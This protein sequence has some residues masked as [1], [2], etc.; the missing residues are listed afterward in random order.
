MNQPNLDLYLVWRYNICHFPIDVLYLWIGQNLKNQPNLVLYLVRRSKIFV[1][2][3]TLV[4]YM[5][6]YRFYSTDSVTSLKQHIEYFNFRC[7]IQLDLPILGRTHFLSLFRSTS[8]FY[9]PRANKRAMAT[10]RPAVKLHSMMNVHVCLALTKCWWQELRSIDLRVSPQAKNLDEE[11]ERGEQ[12]RQWLISES[13]KCKID[14]IP[15]PDNDPGVFLA[16]GWY[17]LL[18][19]HSIN[20]RGAH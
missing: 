16:R 13:R 3:A 11:R 17:P 1:S 12:K 9:S 2:V 14:K 7:S 19:S 5:L 20:L 18:S 6:F 8:Q 4:F 10:Y 15:I